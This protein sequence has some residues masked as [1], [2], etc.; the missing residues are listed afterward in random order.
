MLIHYT[1]GEGK[2]ERGKGCGREDR[3]G[4]VRP[5]ADLYSALMDAGAHLQAWPRGEQ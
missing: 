2:Q 5:A 4:G 3:G 1:L